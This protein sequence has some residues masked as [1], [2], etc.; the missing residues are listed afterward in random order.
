MSAESWADVRTAEF[1]VLEARANLRKL[2]RGALSGNRFRIRLRNVTWTREQLDSKLDALRAHGAPNYFGPQ[3]FGRDGYNLDRVAAWVQ[4]GVAPRGRAERSFALSAARSLV[5]NA[6]LARRVEA[7]D[8]AQLAPGG[9][10]S[11]HRTG[12]HFH[13]PSVDDA[14]RP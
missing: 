6:L 12:S 11:L 2:R 8:W 7:G 5:F 14:L 13:L 3:R 10:A 4:N 1:K 9:V